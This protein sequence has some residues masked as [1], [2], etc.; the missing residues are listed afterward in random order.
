MLRVCRFKFVSCVCH[1]S[2][3][4]CQ[5]YVQVWRKRRYKCWHRQPHCYQSASSYYWH[6]LP[7]HLDHQ[8]HLLTGSIDLYHASPS[9]SGYCYHHVFLRRLRLGGLLF[10][11][12]C[13]RGCIVSCVYFCAC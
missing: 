7:L 11:N 6:L 8:M 9:F 10:N 1:S 13:M 5:L 3:W 4:P 2:S 12:L